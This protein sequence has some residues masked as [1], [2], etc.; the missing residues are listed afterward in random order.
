MP[1]SAIT[2]AI[3][4]CLTVAPS[5]G[6]SLYIS[7]PRLRSNPQRVCRRE[8][9]V[10]V[11]NQAS[12]RPNGHHSFSLEP[13]ESD[14]RSRVRRV[15][16]GHARIDAGQPRVPKRP[17]GTARPHRRRPGENTWRF[18]PSRIERTF[19]S[20]ANATSGTPR[21]GTG[22]ISRPAV[23]GTGV[24]SKETKLSVAWSPGHVP[25]IQETTG[26]PDKGYSWGVGTFCASWT[27]HTRL[28][29]RECLEWHRG[30]TKI[31]LDDA[32]NPRLG[33]RAFQAYRQVAYVQVG[34]R[35]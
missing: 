2:E 31:S 8:N 18:P 14:H 10:S 4:R 35:I 21:S 16:A 19:S 1:H 17:Y 22:V 30:Q 9:V 12:S 15:R 27:G 5:A 28:P 6:N 33:R 7:D 24:G 29:P 11:L 3:L 23:G 34:T 20:K 13:S 26:S 32:E 25:S